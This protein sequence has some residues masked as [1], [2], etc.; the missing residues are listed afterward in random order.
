M[1]AFRDIAP[2]RLVEVYRRFGGS[3]CFHH[4][5]DVAVRTS[6]TSVN[7]DYTAKYPKSLSPSYW[8]LWEP[9][10]SRSNCSRTHRDNDGTDFMFQNVNSQVRMGIEVRCRLEHCIGE[11]TPEVLLK[12]WLDLPKHL[13]I[14]CPLCFAFKAFRGHAVQTHQFCYGSRSLKATEMGI[15]SLFRFVSIWRKRVSVGGS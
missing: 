7:L 10:I 15:T 12:N 2:C 13:D 1:T 4:C 6:E 14:L 8:P 9:V 3:Y 11:I 5:S